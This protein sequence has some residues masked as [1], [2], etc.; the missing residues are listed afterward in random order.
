[1]YVKR[2]WKTQWMIIPEVANSYNKICLIY[3]PRIILYEDYFFIK[4]LFFIL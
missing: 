3:N 4:N 1:M 2:K